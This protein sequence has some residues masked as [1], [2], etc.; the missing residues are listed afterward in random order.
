MAKIIM[1]IVFIIL[2]ALFC[3][4]Y[5]KPDMEFGQSVSGILSGLKDLF[6]SRATIVDGPEIRY[7]VKQSGKKQKICSAHVNYMKFWIGAGSSF[8][9]LKLEDGRVS[10]KHCL[11][12][13]RIRGNDQEFVLYSYSK[14]NP[15]MIWKEDER[16]YVPLKRRKPFVLDGKMTFI[17][18]NTP[19][20]IIT[21]KLK[22]HD[23]PFEQPE[24]M[25]TSY[26]AG[27]TGYRNHKYKNDRESDYP[28]DPTTVFDMNDY[29]L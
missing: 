1:F 13:K 4:L 7:I 11:L 14:K 27:E 12:K 2:C 17:I 21:T 9:D 29:K 26:Q 5:L 28:D 16:I 3:V 22:I 10:R 15:V 24:T 20:Q 18:G 23:N 6:S 25:D 19:V 8:C